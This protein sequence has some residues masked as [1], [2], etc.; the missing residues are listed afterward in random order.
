MSAL[1]TDSRSS[2]S[3]NGQNSPHPTRSLNHAWGTYWGGRYN[4]LAKTLPTAIPHLRATVHAASASE[5][6]RAHDLMTRLYWV[7]GCTLV[8]MGQPDAAFLA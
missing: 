8:H 6:V 1:R 3:E 4:A 7:T 2:Y 5:R